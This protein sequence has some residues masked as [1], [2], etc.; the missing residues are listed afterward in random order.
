MRVGGG[1]DAT[2]WGRRDKGEEGGKF[3]DNI[4]RAGREGENPPPMAEF[5]AGGWGPTEADEMLSGEGRK[6]R[7]L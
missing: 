5:P 6:W 4:G 2:W 3:V 1:G 7:R